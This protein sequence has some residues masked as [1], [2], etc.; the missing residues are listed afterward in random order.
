MIVAKPPKLA[1]PIPAL[2]RARTCEDVV[3]ARGRRW[4]DAVRVEQDL[5]VRVQARVG[6]GQSQARGLGEGLC[7]AWGH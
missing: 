3:E 7:S 4:L 1:R 6:A 5:W 2:Y